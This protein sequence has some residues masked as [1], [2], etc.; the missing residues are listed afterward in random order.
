MASSTA[1]A[2]TVAAFQFAASGDVDANVAAIERGVCSAAELGSRLVVLQECAL[3]G[4]P[5]LE[6]QSV[7]LMKPARLREA[8]RR[9]VEL[10]GRHDLFIAYGT[11]DFQG[12]DA[13]LRLL[14]G[15]RD[16][17]QRNG[18]RG[19]E[20]HAEAARTPAAKVTEPLKAR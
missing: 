14:V 6:T 3:S 9:I 19:R 13:R 20:E 4:Y 8:E 18:E 15:E 5:P 10:A 11:T 12:D 7:A 2:L 1:A 17:R 16:E